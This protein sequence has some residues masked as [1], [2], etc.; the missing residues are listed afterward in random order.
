[1]NILLLFNNPSYKLL[2]CYI[3]FQIVAVPLQKTISNVS[4]PLLQKNLGENGTGIRKDLTAKTPP[5]LHNITVPI[6]TNTNVNPSTT[7]NTNVKPINN[8]EDLGGFGDP[9]DLDTEDGEKR[10]NETL[11]EHNVTSTKTVLIIFLNYFIHYR[12]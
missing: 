7:V 3:V 6:S 2:K 1:M 11:T 4:I 5:L 12:K 9:D 8:V 10:F